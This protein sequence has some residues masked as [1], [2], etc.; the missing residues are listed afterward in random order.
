[1]YYYYLLNLIVSFFSNKYC[2]YFLNY[3]ILQNIITIALL[4]IYSTWG[5]S[6]STLSLAGNFIFS[7]LLIMYLVFSI[8]ILIAFC[9]Q[10]WFLF[11]INLQKNLIEIWVYLLYTLSL[12]IPYGIFTFVN[13]PF[14]SY[15]LCW[16]LTI[17]F[18]FNDNIKNNIY[19]FFLY[20]VSALI[21]V[22]FILN[23][24]PVKSNFCI[25]EDFNKIYLIKMV[26]KNKVYVHDIS[27]KKSFVSEK[28]IEYLLLPEIKKNFGITKPCIL[29]I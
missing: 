8:I 29:Y 1:M 27:M 22:L 4:P 25:V 13:A 6:F 21:F 28:K 18:I 19:Y 9:F 11:V 24:I 5:I 12:Y 2:I 23:N 16:G 15:P 3:S 17:V 10:K 20:T 7:P 26:D 14:I